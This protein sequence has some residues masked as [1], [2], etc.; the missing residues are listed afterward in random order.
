VGV[1]H[2]GDVVRR[3]GADHVA[4][5]VAPG[6]AD[7]HLPAVREGLGVMPRPETG[8]VCDHVSWP[9]GAC[10]DVA[11]FAVETVDR[12]GVKL[13]TWQTCEAHLAT[14]VWL[15]LRPGARVD[16]VTVRRGPAYA[17][18]NPGE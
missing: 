7:H 1:G 10:I 9:A 5:A 11:M 16:Q 18:G 15:M 4:P 17:T 13:P 8:D 2:P 6:D 3:L 14:R 12:H